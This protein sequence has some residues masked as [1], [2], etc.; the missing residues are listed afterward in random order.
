MLAVYM[1][2]MAPRESPGLFLISR[3]EV[4]TAFADRFLRVTLLTLSSSVIY[5]V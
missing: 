4:S 5:K 1:M 2:L 3:M